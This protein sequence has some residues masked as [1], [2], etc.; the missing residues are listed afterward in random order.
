M[1]DF[2]TV[3][4]IEVHVKVGDTVAIDDSLIT[5]ETDKATMDVPS[6]YA[7]IIV[8][9]CSAVGDKISEGDKIAVLESESVTATP[10]TAPRFR[11]T[12]PILSMYF[13]V[14]T[15]L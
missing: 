7:G 15:K 10:I 11:E 8:E 2:K 6:P 13:R 5:L 1:G 14:I 4:V 12:A 9:M 3:D